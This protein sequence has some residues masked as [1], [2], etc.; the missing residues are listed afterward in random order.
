[1]A[2]DILNV[3]HNKIDALRGNGVRPYGARFEKTNTLSGLRSDFELGKLTMENVVKA[4]GRIM[5]VREHGKSAFLD[6][7]DHTSKI[8]LYVK[9]DDVTGGLWDLLDIG[10]IIGAEGSLF[11]TRTG[12]ITINASGLTMLS[13]SLRP[14]PEK[15]HG[16]KDI[17]TRYRQ[18]YLDLISNDESMHVFMTR[19]RIIKSIRRFFDERGY[20]EVETPMLHPIAGGAAG[21]PFK[22]Y[23]N[24]YEKDLYLRIAPELYLKRLLVGGMEKVYEINRSFR[25]EGVST[26]HNPEFT[27]LEAYAAYA[28]YNDL[29]P[30]MENLVSGLVYEI[31]GKKETMYKGKLINFEPPWERVSFTLMMKELYGVDP[32]DDADVWAGKLKEKGVKLEGDKLS[33]TRLINIVADLIEPKSDKGKPI[34]VTD[35]FTEL[36]P[37]AKTNSENP[38]ISER[39][40]LYMGGMEVAN[41]YS[42]LNDPSEQERRFKAQLDFDKETSDQIDM[43]YIR[44]LEYGMP[45][46]AG[47]GIGIDRLVMILTGSESI[48]DVIL[49]PQLKP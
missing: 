5:S 4:A 48:R 46:A 29:M 8:Q 47:L 42:E 38:A 37:L 24:V 2:D 43:D 10:D 16:L 26:R 13:K 34:F 44:A 20:A 1:M 36:C 17:E 27:M 12:E 41:A 31:T 23:H 33:K 15:W 28:D 11:K 14:L 3:R 18:R 45:P 49:F 30:L 7:K 9:K 6:I 32:N 39:F 21:R 22:T 19:C 35:Y 25:N 40:E